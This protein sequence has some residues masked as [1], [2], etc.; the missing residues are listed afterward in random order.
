MY[1][2]SDKCIISDETLVIWWN[3]S[4]RVLLWVNA[5]PGPGPGHLDMGG[6]FFKKRVLEK[7]ARP[8][9]KS[10]RVLIYLVYFLLIFYGLGPD[11]IS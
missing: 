4:G 8:I 9:W 11:P 7:T 6:N 1:S 10:Y 5:G 2:I 3:P